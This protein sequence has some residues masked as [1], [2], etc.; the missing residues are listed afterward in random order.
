M[1]NGFDQLSVWH[2]VR[3]DVAFLV[4]WQIFL[5]DQVREFTPLEERGPLQE[6]CF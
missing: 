5:D 1:G 6:P 3:S 4:L 2:F